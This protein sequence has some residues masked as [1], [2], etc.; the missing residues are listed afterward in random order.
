MLL[1]GGT[2]GRYLPNGHLVY[3][4]Q[5][6]VFAV[7]FDIGKLEVRGTHTPVLENVGYSPQ[8]GSAQFDFSQTGTLLYQGGGAGGRMVT[9]QWLDG[10]GKMRP[11]LSKPGLY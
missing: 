1:R 5:G 6:T 11:L 10:A 4:N 9:I 3:L 8:Y 7:P 2:Y